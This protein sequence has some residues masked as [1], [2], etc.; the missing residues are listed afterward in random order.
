VA[1]SWRTCILAV[2]FQVLVTGLVQSTIQ[3]LI[4]PAPGPHTG[5]QIN[6]IAELAGLSSI[7]V[8][9][10]VSIVL[11]LVYLKMR[12]LGGQLPGQ[13]LPQLEIDSHS[14][15]EQRVRTRLSERTGKS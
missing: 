2:G 9:P 1:R 8:T 6:V 3:R 4:N 11:A 15:W 10:L 7:F 12:Q 5:M 13:L 14:P